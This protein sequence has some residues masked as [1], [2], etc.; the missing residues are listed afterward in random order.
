MSKTNLKLSEYGISNK[1]YKELCG[2]CEQYPEWKSKLE[3]YSIM[4]GMEY[5]DMPK[6]HNNN[7]QVEQLVI[8][9]ESLIKKVKMIEDAAMQADEYYARF[10]IM[11]AC[12]EKGYAYLQTMSNMPLSQ[13]AFYR[14]RRKFFY[15]LD[16][17][18]NW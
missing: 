9:R 11:S 17:A 13:N 1:R 12:Y 15:I 16:K 3:E 8:K 14:K 5:T 7:S 6:A 18:H 10:I 2:F 4:C